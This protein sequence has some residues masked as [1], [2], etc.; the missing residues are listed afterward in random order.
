MQDSFKSFI[1][2]SK[3]ILIL[4]PANPK[5]DEVA[6][7][8]S[9]YLGFKGQKE[10]TVVSHSD[11]IVAFNRLVGVN[12]IAREFGNKNLTIRF[13]GYDAEG[14]EKVSYDIDGGEFRLKIVPKDGV[15]SP[16]ENQIQ[17]SYAGVAADTIFLIGGE[18]EEDFPAIASDE[19]K[20][21]KILHLGITALQSAP[22]RI[23]SL[24]RPTSSISELVATLIKE[25][26]VS[27]SSDLATNLL[28]GIEE[29]TKNFTKQEVTADTFALVAELM[30]SGGSRLP[31]EAAPVQPQN[32]FG[33]A[34]G[35]TRPP[36]SW[37]EPKIFKGTSVS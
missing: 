18:K 21:A 25:S 35:G 30:R 17:M 12:K 22:G 1:D 15:A 20:G 5:F 3:S 14:I 32:V 2:S 13:V 26:G 33:Q 34:G 31:Q 24:A 29:G 19:L 28:M 4:L 23:I 37:L 27:L 8:L 11:M 9:F 16:Q 10:I 6:A 36:K 7:G